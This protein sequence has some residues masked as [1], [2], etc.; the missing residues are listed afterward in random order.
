MKML[1][2]YNEFLSE[3]SSDFIDVGGIKTAYYFYDGNSDKTIL[4]IHGIGGDFHGMIPLA[5]YLKDSANVL[6]VDL[7]SH[8]K[9]QLITDIEISDIECWSSSLLLAFQQK[10]LQVDEIIAHS[11]GC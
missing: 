5:H 7:P 11:L 10:N 1:L 2:M 3:I 8:G 4:L 6:F 9:S